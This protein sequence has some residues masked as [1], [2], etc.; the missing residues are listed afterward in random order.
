LVKAG[1]LLEVVL[2]SSIRKVDNVHT[3]EGTWLPARLAE[4]MLDLPHSK[5]HSAK[6]SAESFRRQK[7]GSMTITTLREFIETAGKQTRYYRD[8]LRELNKLENREVHVVTMRRYGNREAHSY[9]LGVWS[10]RE[11]AEKNG[12]IENLWRGGKYEPDI[13]TW[14]VDANE[15]DK[16][17]DISDVGEKE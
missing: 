2:Q 17:S 7:E 14:V 6:I 1:A 13:S 11:E 16:I 4:R 12:H 8:F 5:V 10:T 9:V 15:H 3:A